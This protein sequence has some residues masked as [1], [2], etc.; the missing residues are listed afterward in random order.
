MPGLGDGEFVILFKE[1]L[2]PVALEFR[3]D[4]ILFVHPALAG[5]GVGSSLL[6]LLM[7]AVRG[8]GGSHMVSG[9]YANW[10]TSL[11]MHTK[12]GFRVHRRLTQCRVLNIFPTPPKAEPL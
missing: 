8:Q 9:L 3:P 4:F 12:V 7:K 5:R 10:H 2:R 1:I 6:G 11:R